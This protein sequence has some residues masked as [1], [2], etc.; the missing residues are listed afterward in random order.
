M[1]G[2]DADTNGSVAR[3]LLGHKFGYYN[4]PKLLVEGLNKRDSPENYFEKYIK[5]INR[6]VLRR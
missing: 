6:M 2:G 3:S 5:V 1:E 4:I